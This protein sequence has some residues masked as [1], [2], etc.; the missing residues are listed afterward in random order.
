MRPL[1]LG[2]R[3]DCQSFTQMALHTS[4]WN[5]LCPSSSLFNDYCKL[6]SEL[7][8]SM[9]SWLAF[10]RISLLSRQI[11]LFYG[12]LLLF[13]IAYIYFK[14]WFTVGRDEGML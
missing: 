10:I 7:F 12:R 2:K 14:F 4:S 11:L 3:R 1:F 8:V 9:I 6:V 5:Q 13:F